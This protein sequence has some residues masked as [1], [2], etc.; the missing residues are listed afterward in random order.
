VTSP[1]DRWSW[2]GLAAHRAARN[3]GWNLAGGGTTGLL[4]V[5]ATPVFV[6]R[7]GLEGYGIVGIWLVLQ[8]MMGVLDLGMGPALVRAY[9]GY[10]LARD[11]PA[12]RTDLL[13]TLELFYWAIAILLTLV[14]AGLAGWI[15]AHWLTTTEMAPG[16][17]RRALVLMALALGAQFPGAVYTNGLAGLQA[18]GR[19]NLLQVVGSFVRYGGA[20]TLLYWRPDVE[21]FFALQ[22]VVSLAQTLAGRALLRRSL[23]PSASARPAFRSALLRTQWRFSTG[24]AATAIAAALMANADRVALSA[25]APAAELGKYAVAF[26]ATGLLQ[27]GIQPFYRAFFPR[28]SELVSAGD[29]PALE[30]EYVRSCVLLAAVL[31]PL[32]VVGG[33]FAPELLTAWLGDADPTVVAVFRWLLLAITAS[34]LVWLP[35]A[36]QQAHGWTQLHAGMI[37]GALVV[38]T[39]AMLWAIETIGTVGASLVWV[40][41]GLSGL[42]LELWLMHRRLLVGRL[43]SWYRSV[44]APPLL[45]AFPVAVTARWNMPEGLG[46][47]SALAWAATA[48]ALA[49][50]LSA[51]AAWRHLAADPST[52]PLEDERA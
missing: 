35:A 30:R 47:W 29:G 40:L 46:R 22:A 50:G 11:G 31:V 38:G 49:L 52:I 44:L 19:M 16:T 25:L 26:T 36:F 8:V 10:Q 39:P 33:T 48:G 23:D 20:A 2:R 34:G 12:F 45:W 3:V 1:R 32:G 4:I 18:H 5:L 17:V 24:M 51:A 6:A 41:H 14:L 27:L 13:R 42:T 7:L 43:A 28:F 9:A 37:T 21:A 15:A